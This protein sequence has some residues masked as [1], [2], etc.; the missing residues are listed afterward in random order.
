M[1]DVYVAPLSR[2]NGLGSELLESLD[3]ELRALGIA[4]IDTSVHFDNSG[5]KRFY[6]RNGFRVLGEERLSRLL[7]EAN[8]TK[9][10][11]SDAH[12]SRR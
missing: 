3:T 2:N 6:E 7:G 11:H 5:A 10:M 4:R 1:D 9:A 12:S 8:P